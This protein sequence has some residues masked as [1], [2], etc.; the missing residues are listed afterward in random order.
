MPVICWLISPVALAV[1][2]ASAFT[3]DAT[4]AKPRPASPARAASMVA[5]SASRLVCPAMVLI[6][7]TTSPIRLAACASSPTRSLV[8]RA[9]STASLAM[10]DEV[11]TWRLIS[12][13]DEAISSVADATDCTL[14]EASSEAAATMV[15]SSC[16][17]SA[18]AVS[19]PAEASSSV[20]AEDTVSMISPTATSKSSASLLHVRLALLDGLRFDRLLLDLH[21]LDLYSA[22]LE[23]GQRR[24]DL[25]DLVAAPRCRCIDREVAA[26]QSLHDADAGLQGPCHAARS[27]I[28]DRHDKQ[29]HGQR[30]VDDGPERVI[31]GLEK[32]GGLDPDIEDAEQL[33]VR[34]QDRIVLRHIG[35]AEDLDLTAKRRLALDHQFVSRAF[36]QARPHRPRAIRLL[37]ICRD[38]QIVQKD[39]TGASDQVLDLVHGRHV[40]IQDVT[41]EEQLAVDAAEILAIGAQHVPRDPHVGL[42]TLLRRL[43]CTGF[44]HIPG[45]DGDT[46]AQQQDTGDG[47]DHDPRNEPESFRTTKPGGLF[48]QRPHKDIPICLSIDMRYRRGTQAENRC[49]IP[50]ITFEWYREMLSGALIDFCMQEADEMNRHRLRC[51]RYYRTRCRVGGW[52]R[53]RRRLLLPPPSAT[54]KRFSAPA[55]PAG[56]SLE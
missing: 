34:I 29:G 19:V 40:V 56:W 51:G 4:T 5:L 13:T 32:I 26:R 24:H 18:V 43:R 12:L 48:T 45:H 39:G 22:G 55:R 49:R 8:L 35:R 52:M 53:R 50:A 38:S 6:S 37:N 17:R 27:Q 3:S 7:S 33:A 41:I 9:W 30:R 23:Y 36:R 16:D 21:S 28:A 14:V 20:E 47:E 46:R 11:C 42:N 2:S 10:F 31:G 54:K 44:Q 1:C 25:A 15:V